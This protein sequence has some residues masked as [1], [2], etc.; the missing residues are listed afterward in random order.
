MSTRLSAARRARGHAGEAFRSAQ[1]P[2][3]LLT[4]PVF[5]P[6]VTG[7]PGSRFDG[8][9]ERVAFVPGFDHDVFISYAHIDNER[10]RWVTKLAKELELRLAEQLGGRPMIWM[11]D[12]IRGNE[13]LTQIMDCLQKAATLLLIHSQASVLSGWCRKEVVSFMASQ[14]AERNRVFLVRTKPFDASSEPMNLRDLPG[15]TFWREDGGIVLRL[16]T[17]EAGGKDR[18]YATELAR[19]ATQL[20]ETLTDAVRIAEQAGQR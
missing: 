15:Y 16:G 6:T 2:Q 18:K 19:L 12:K 10:S 20:A 9:E 14:N 5:R 3:I 8:E 4:A 11:D 7:A 1:A 13:P 17:L